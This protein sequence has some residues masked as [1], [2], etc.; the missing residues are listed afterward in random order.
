MLY[1]YNQNDYANIPYNKPNGEKATVKSGGCGVCSACIVFNTLAQ[2]ELYSVKKMAEFSID[3]GAR[4]NNGTDEKTLLTALC[5]STKGFS[6]TTT[7]DVKE[8]TA[9]LKK[10]GMAICNQGNAYNVFSTAG[11]YVVAWKMF[12]K[13]IEV[14]DPQT[15][16]GKYD[17]APRP[18]RIVTKTAYGCIVKPSEMKKAT[19]DRSPCYYLVTYKKPSN[20]PS[21]HTGDEVT[22]KANNALY[23]RASK[24]D[25]FTVGDLSQFKCGEKAQLKKGSKVKVLAVDTVKGSLWLKIKVNGIECYILAYSKAKDKSYVK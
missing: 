25:Y 10:G 20:K 14:V 22:L 21:V 23:L 5:K 1:Y 24:K 4:I 7:N 3:C 6:F 15:Y 18:K 9:H 12:D 8:L 17:K 11:H 16:T 13:N 2:K 19:A